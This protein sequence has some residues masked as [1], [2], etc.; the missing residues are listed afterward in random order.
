MRRIRWFPDNSLLCSTFGA[1][2]ADS[3]PLTIVLGNQVVREVRDDAL[4]IKRVIA[5]ERL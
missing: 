3:E 2:R 5:D 4:W 1:S